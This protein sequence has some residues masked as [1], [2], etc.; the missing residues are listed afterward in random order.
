MTANRLKLAVLIDADNV[1]PDSVDRVMDSIKGVGNPVVR[2]IYGGGDRTRSKKWSDVMSRHAFSLGRRTPQSA[3][4]N[5]TDI[6]M[7][8]GAMD[9]LSNGCLQGYCLV[10]SDSDFAALAIRLRRSGKLVFGFGEDKT[11]ESFRHSCD[12]FH[13]VGAAPEI[14]EAPQAVKQPLPLKH[15]IGL[16]TET[17]EQCGNDGSVTLQAAGAHLKAKHPKFAARTYGSAGLKSLIKK[18]G[19]F[20]LHVRNGQ[21]AFRPARTGP[22]LKLVRP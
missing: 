4:Y 6:E 19:A 17:F 13:L 20:E 9:L 8:I 10:S 16:L 5:A 1:S 22:A 12:A 14:A 15:A 21:D 7:V 18:C 3:G 11:P 2:E